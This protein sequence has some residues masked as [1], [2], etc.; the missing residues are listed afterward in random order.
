[1][2][3]VTM[4]VGRPPHEGFIAVKSFLQLTVNSALSIAPFPDT[5]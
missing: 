5:A 1:M 4:Q 3:E 2:A